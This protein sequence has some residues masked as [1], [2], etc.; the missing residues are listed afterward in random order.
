MPDP[1]LS[2][3]D[4]LVKGTVPASYRPLVWWSHCNPLCDSARYN[5]QNALSCSHFSLT[6]VYGEEADFLASLNRRGN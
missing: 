1:V 3:G 2:V 6:A 5:L 4:T